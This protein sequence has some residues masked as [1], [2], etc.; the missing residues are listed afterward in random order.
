MTWSQNYDPLGGLGWSALVASLPVVTLLG[1]LA[2]FHVRAHVAA[3]A[4]LA[5]AWVTATW[6]YGM[7]AK[8]AGLSALNGAMFGLFPI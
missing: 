4:G 2:W 3:L 7:P 8:L 1:L 6:V 5:V